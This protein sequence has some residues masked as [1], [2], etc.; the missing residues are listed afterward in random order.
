MINPRR[1]DEVIRRD[2]GSLSGVR[3]HQ[4]AAIGRSYAILVG[5]G[6]RAEPGAAPNRWPRR[7]TAAPTPVLASSRVCY[8]GIRA[9]TWH[10]SA[11]ERLLVCLQLV[12][13]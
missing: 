1:V 6:R 12:L 9:V 4:S 5:G 13:R 3:R 8:N 11:A 10:G 7:P 2:S